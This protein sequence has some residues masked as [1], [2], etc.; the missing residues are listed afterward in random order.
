MLPLAYPGPHGK[1]F[2]TSIRPTT[3]Q[4]RWDMLLRAF[5]AL[6]ECIQEKGQPG[7]TTSPNA[8]G[9]VMLISAESAMARKWSGNAVGLG[10]NSTTL[11]LVDTS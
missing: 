7:W 11:N 1:Y 4:E 9:I 3:T 10:M 6:R 2:K 5:E 8:G